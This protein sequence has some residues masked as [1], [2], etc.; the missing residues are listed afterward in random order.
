MKAKYATP[1]GTALTSP[2][3]SE[4]STGSPTVETTGATSLLFAEKIVSVLVD[5]FLLAPVVEKCIIYPEI[6]QNLERYACLFKLF[7]SEC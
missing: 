5:L 1:N 2:N 4:V 7:Y 6:I 3:S